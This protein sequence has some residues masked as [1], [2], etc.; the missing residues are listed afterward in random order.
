MYVLGGGSI[1]Y[2]VSG[3]DTLQ[4]TPELDAQEQ[5]GQLDFRGKKSTSYPQ[6]DIAS[7]IATRTCNILHAYVRC[8][9]LWQPA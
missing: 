8:K 9:Y 2:Y 6:G 5:P 4:Q 3:A 7:N 1:R